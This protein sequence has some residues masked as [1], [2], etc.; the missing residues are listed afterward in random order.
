MT[1]D[2]RAAR[3]RVEAV[4]AA[5]DRLTPDDLRLTPM[6]VRDAEVRE[7]L[8]AHLEDAAVDAD[9]GTLLGEARSWLRDAIGARTLARYAPEAGVWGVAAGGVVRDRVE[10]FLALEDAVSVAATQDLLDPGEAAL[11]ADPGRRLLGLEPLTV[12]GLAAEPL[13]N[14]WEPSATDWAAA[15]GEGPAAVDP[16]EPMAGSRT[17]QRAVFG[18]LGAFA[19]A[20]ALLYG[21]ATDQ[22]LLGI[23]GAGAA[24]AVA[25]TFATW[26]SAGR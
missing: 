25:F 10:V 3:E 17:V 26:R 21:I 11:L 4:Y 1:D 20:F 12:P 14:A 13:P 2:D 8:V 18:T 23:L 22:L 24:G 7:R 9:R 19:V 6:P 15:G 16:D 5:V